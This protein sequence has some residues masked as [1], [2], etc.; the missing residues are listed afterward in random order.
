MT[1]LSRKQR[2]ALFRVWSREWQGKPA[3]YRAFR[4]T[5]IPAFG[6]CIMVPWCG[7]ILGIESDGYTHS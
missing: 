7:M 5:V 2:V 1:V 6:D 3:S 4:R